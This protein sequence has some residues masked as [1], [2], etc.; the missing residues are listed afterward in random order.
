M[1]S[2][3][4]MLLV[5]PELH[6]KLKQENLSEL[7]KEMH[8]ILFSTENSD[9]IKWKLYSQSLQR[10]LHYAREMNKNVEVEMKEKEYRDPL[11]KQNHLTQRQK[12]LIQLDENL[13]PELQEQGKK[14][15]K[16]LS[17]S[18]I[19][20]WNKN[21]ELTMDDKLVRG[22]DIVEFVSIGVKPKQVIVP[23]GFNRFAELLDDSA[24]PHQYFGPNILAEEEEDEGEMDD[25]EQNAST[26]SHNISQRTPA[27]ANRSQKRNR[28]QFLPYQHTW[29]K[30]N[31]QNPI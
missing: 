12:H 5:P 20:K 25:N 30:Y 21:G 6:S 28:T 16:L 31:F 29:E 19:I 1:S 26:S 15:Y 4:A 9:E 7:D 2:A 23:K 13:P 17:E 22:S 8:Q 3:R 18:K 14:L 11:K 27:I 24:L 10:Y